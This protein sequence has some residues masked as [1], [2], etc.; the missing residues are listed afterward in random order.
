[1]T[2]KWDTKPP[3]STGI[4]DVTLLIER[5]PGRPFR[6]VA[7]GYYDRGKW[8]IADTNLFDTETVIAWSKRREPYAGPIKSVSKIVPMK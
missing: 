6:M 1:M 3:P 5:V 2:P 8:A 7:V 4:Y